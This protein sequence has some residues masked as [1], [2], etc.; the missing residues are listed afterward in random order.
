MSGSGEGQKGTRED[1]KG[2]NGLHQSMPQHVDSE[3]K[4]KTINSRSCNLPR[5][6]PPIPAGQ[7]GARGGIVRGRKKKKTRR[8]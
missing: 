4:A 5:S 3:A 2:T 6:L 8:W 1:A 7:K